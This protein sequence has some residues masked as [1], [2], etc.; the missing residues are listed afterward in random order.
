[1]IISSESE[2]FAAFSQIENFVLTDAK[3]KHLLGY[4][5]QGRLLLKR[6]KERKTK[7]RKK[8]PPMNRCKYLF[9]IYQAN[10]ENSVCCR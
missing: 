7:K 1:L 3:T 5:L 8:A 6:K 9:F 4:V 2:S 10:Y